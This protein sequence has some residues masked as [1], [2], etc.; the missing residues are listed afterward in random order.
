MKG[1]GILE[2]L[3]SE[4]RSTGLNGTVTFSRH[5]LSTYYGSTSW[6]TKR[7]QT[8][9]CLQV[10]CKIVE[11]MEWE[12]VRCDIPMAYSIIDVCVRHNVGPGGKIMNP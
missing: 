4:I 12:T 11:K 6:D 3:R 2:G 10:V 7:H 8:H 1:E 5:L 9:S